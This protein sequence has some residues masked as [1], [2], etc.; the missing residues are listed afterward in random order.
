M[1]KFSEKPIRAD[2]EE[3][4]LLVAEC[5]GPSPLCLRLIAAMEKTKSPV[6]LESAFQFLTRMVGEFCSGGNVKKLF[7]VAKL[8]SLARDSKVGLG[9]RTP[10][11]KNAA[12]ALI[13][14]VCKNSRDPGG[15]N[16][17]RPMLEEE[18]RAFNIA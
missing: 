5:L 17:V 9:H 10:K 16:S 2:L 14:A 8:I 18:G 1:A 15:M 13:L 12:E 3:M 4:Y 11:V 6:A 7:N